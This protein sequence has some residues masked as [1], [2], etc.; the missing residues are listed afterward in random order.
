MTTVAN[1]GADS[2]AAK[3]AAHLRLFLVHGPDEGLVRERARR[4]EKAWLDGADDPFAIVSL[5]GD[6]VA[7]DPG[8]LA[9]EAFAVSMFGGK[10]AIRVEI[11]ARDAAAA[12]AAL[13]ERPPAD[14]A[15]IALAGALR[16][17][18][19]LRSLFEGSRA[20]AS[21]ECYPDEARDLARL[22]EET[23]RAEGLAVDPDAREALVGLLGDDRMT[24][25]S[26]LA[27]LALYSAGTG[28]VT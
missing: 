23:L 25:R 6:E 1:S 10:R 14:C 28:R 26:E 11:G 18:H 4:I 17:G 9:D 20:A 27:K 8:K 7:Q 21:V 19:A 13:V 16:K 24:T 15:V 12:F 5:A 3:P 22:V 2:F